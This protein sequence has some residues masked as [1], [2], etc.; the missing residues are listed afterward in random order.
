MANLLT[1]ADFIDDCQL[2]I[3]TIAEVQTAFNL[4]LTKMEAE[5]LRKVLGV[6]SMLHLKQYGRQIQQQEFG[7]N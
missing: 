5:F 2:S 1:S 6:N 3:S 7:L 4:F